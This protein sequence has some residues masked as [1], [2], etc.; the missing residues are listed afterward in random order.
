MFRLVCVRYLREAKQCER[1]ICLLQARPTQ[2]TIRLLDYRLSFLVLHL[3]CSLFI[4]F[5][6]FRTSV[7]W[8]LNVIALIIQSR[9]L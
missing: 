1:T 2:Y 7:G 3:N 9:L 5:A 8:A 6:C 4:D